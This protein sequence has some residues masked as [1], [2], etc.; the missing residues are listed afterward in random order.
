L[1]NRQQELEVEERKWVRSIQTRSELKSNFCL[2]A[3]RIF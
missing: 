3:W 2:P 1:T